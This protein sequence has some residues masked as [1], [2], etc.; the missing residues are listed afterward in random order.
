MPQT[1]TNIVND[2]NGFKIHFIGLGL[3]L[4]L[5]QSGFSQMHKIDNIDIVTNFVFLR[6]CSFLLY[7]HQLMSVQ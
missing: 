4:G 1:E 5:C 2:V 7:L 3:G 6:N